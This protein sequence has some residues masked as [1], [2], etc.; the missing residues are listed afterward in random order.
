[1]LAARYDTRILF[2]TAVVCGTGA[3]G[4]VGRCVVPSSGASCEY[5]STLP[6]SPL[7]RTS[8]H[9]AH[10]FCRG[11]VRRAPTATDTQGAIPDE[12]HNDYDLKEVRRAASNRGGIS[13]RCVRPGA[14]FGAP[15]AYAAKNSKVIALSSAEAEYAAASHT[16]REV[17]FIRHVLMDLGFDLQV[18]PS[19]E[20]TIPLRSQ[21]AKIAAS[22]LSQN[23]LMLRPIKF[24]IATSA[25]LSILHSYR[26]CRN[27]LMV[28]P[29][30]WIKPNLKLGFPRFY[31]LTKRIR[32]P[33]LMLDRITMRC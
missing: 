31:V 16:C 25:G 12:V 15:I 33:Y 20:S 6:V 1:M 17:Q 22:L 10:D 13:N 32:M 2:R 27:A 14:V 3:W 28:L 26:L 5:A 21:F 4:C 18:Q 23:T 29:S 24:V 11:D 19:W 7:S 30:L 8:P 9:G